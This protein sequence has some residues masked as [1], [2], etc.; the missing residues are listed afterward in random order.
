MADETLE[1]PEESSN[2]LRAALD[3]GD[4]AVGGFNRREA[5]KFSA[6]VAGAAAFATPVVV[7]AFSAPALAD[8]P[9]PV[10]DGSTDSLAIPGTITS[11]IKQ[12][13]NCGDDAVDPKYGRYNA[14]KGTFNVGNVTGGKVCIGACDTV[15]NFDVES[16][17]YTIVNPPG[18]ECTAYWSLTECPKKPGSGTPKTST[19][20]TGAPSDALPLPYCE[21]ADKC[22]DNANNFLLLE[23]VWC[24]PTTP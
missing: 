12:N 22:T 15:D 1:T 18:F 16:S 9:T 11:G 7:S 4:S 8:G 19:V 6:K 23:K 20:P 10:C 5:L 24:C 2:S 21:P 14:Q 17:W 13:Q 3:V